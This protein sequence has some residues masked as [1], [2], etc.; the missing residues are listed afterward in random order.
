M[1]ACVRVYVCV[2]AV[3]LVEKGKQLA[4]VLCLVQNRKRKIVGGEYLNRSPVDL[5]MT[6]AEAKSKRKEKNGKEKIV[7]DF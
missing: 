6:T 5:R 4:Q 3:S 7:I 1:C 2:V